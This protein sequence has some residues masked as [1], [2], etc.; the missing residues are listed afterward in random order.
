MRSF[1]RV[2]YWCCTGV[3]TEEPIGQVLIGGIVPGILTTV[4]LMITAWIAVRMRPNYAPRP[5]EKPDLSKLDAIRLIWAVPVIFG[6]SMGGIYFGIFTRP[7][8]AVPA[9]SCRSCTGS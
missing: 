3:L 5:A 4:L 6:I 7:K 2:P 1:R 9:P 8:P